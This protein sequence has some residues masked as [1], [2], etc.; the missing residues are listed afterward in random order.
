MNPITRSHYLMIAKIIRNTVPEEHR[1]KLVKEMM[2]F[3]SSVTPCMDTKRFK[4]IA[5]G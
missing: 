4:S 1:S 3:I 2:E 5:N